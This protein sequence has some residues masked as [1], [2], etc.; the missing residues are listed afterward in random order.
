MV[1]IP[2]TRQLRVHLVSYGEAEQHHLLQDSGWISFY[3][4]REGDVENA[5]RLFE[6]SYLQKMAKR[7]KALR[8]DTVAERLSALRF[9]QPVNEVILNLKH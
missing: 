6:L 4:R 8:A 7:N 1:D 3:L 9:S 5:V 2:F